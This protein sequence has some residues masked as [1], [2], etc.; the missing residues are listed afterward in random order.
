M[1]SLLLVVP[2]LS[3]SCWTLSW[4]TLSWSTLSCWTL[5]FRVQSS[6]RF[7]S[8]VAQEWV[9]G[10]RRRRWLLP[11]REPQP[12]RQRVMQAPQWL[13]RPARR[14]LR[15]RELRRWRYRQALRHCLRLARRLRLLRRVLPR[16]RLRQCRPLRQPFRVSPTKGMEALGQLREWR[17]H[18][19]TAH[20]ASLDSGSGPFTC[21]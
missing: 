19:A 18:S 21:H 11:A 9:T 13:E 7:Q 2:L 15:H 17:A 12:T 10:L 8:Q 16:L 4:S 3:W 6:T 14:P 20:L 1:A 5:S